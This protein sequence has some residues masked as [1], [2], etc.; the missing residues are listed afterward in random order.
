MAAWEL[1]RLRDIH[2]L[3]INLTFSWTSIPESLVKI[4]SQGYQ[5]TIHQFSIQKLIS[6]FVFIPMKISLPFIWGII[7]FCSND[8][9]FRILKNNSQLL[10]T[11]LYVPMYKYSHGIWNS[12]VRY[13]WI[14]QFSPFVFSLQVV[15]T[16]D[17]T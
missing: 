3:C 4:N 1:Y 10:C 12:I 16:F 8:G 14:L 17:L 11:S 2:T 15:T 6:F 13:V 9:F 7:Y 5:I